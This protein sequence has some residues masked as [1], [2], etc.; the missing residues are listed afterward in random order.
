MKTDKFTESISE[1]S[2]D[3]SGV[4]DPKFLNKWQKKA[5]EMALDKP[6]QLIQGPPG[7]HY[8]INGVCN[9]SSSLHF[10]LKVQ[11]RV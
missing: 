11:A 1:W 7:K 5:M 9:T 8:S 10:I 4:H 6:F 3:S 2:S